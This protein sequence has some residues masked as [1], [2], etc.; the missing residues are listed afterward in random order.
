[1]FPEVIPQRVTPRR[2][3]RVA[4]RRVAPQ[5]VAPQRV[6]RQRVAPHGFAPQ[7]VARQRVARQRVARQRVAARQCRPLHPPTCQGEDSDID[8]MIDMLR[9]DP[10]S[11]RRIH[12]SYSPNIPGLPI[13]H[14]L[15]QKHFKCAKFLLENGARCGTAGI[16]LVVHPNGNSFPDENKILQ[17][18]Q[19][20]LK[21]DI[22]KL[23][24][25][26]ENERAMFFLAISMVIILQNNWY[27]ILQTL[28]ED[29]MPATI[30]TMDGHNVG[31]P[32]ISVLY[33]AIFS[34]NFEAIRLLLL[35][36]A[37]LYT[38]I[39]NG[40]LQITNALHCLM[41]STVVRNMTDPVKFFKCFTILRG[42]GANFWPYRPARW[43]GALGIQTIQRVPLYREIKERSDILA[44]KVAI[45]MCTPR[46]LL[47]LSRQALHKAMGR[48]YWKNVKDLEVPDGLKPYLLWQVGFEEAF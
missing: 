6:A 19:L 34:I 36:G 20:L 35:H 33:F 48:N 44:A 5:R 11:I 42:F 22:T 4:S 14:A 43:N 41:T 15:M 38:P 12:S 7:R 46:S 31:I 27:T 16:Y 26:F 8:F 3:R 40:M 30:Y 39:H 10:Q 37:E 23:D 29:G 9:R 18:I 24:Y 45:S 17:I 28:L 32:Y 25:L 21:H 1:L 47:D 2:R 13:C